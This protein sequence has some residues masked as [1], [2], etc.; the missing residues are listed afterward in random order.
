MKTN[1]RFLFGIVVFII[2]LLGTTFLI[3]YTRP[4]PAYLPED[5]PQGVAHNYLL[6]LQDKD[7]E[8]AYSYLHP[9]LKGYP[10]TAE[11]FSSSISRY[12]WSF[13]NIASSS[14]EVSP[15][16]KEHQLVTTRVVVHEL[17]FRERGFF[18]STETKQDFTVTLQKRK[19]QWLITKSES[20]W[21]W[22]W[23]DQDG[24]H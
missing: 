19:D 16:A 6:A 1:D 24:C 14:F 20:Y 12:S 10:Q 3:A 17:N 4:E 11:D 21:L 23:D 9:K 22:C 8:R 13:R 7:Y 15:P 5:T 18:D 2:L